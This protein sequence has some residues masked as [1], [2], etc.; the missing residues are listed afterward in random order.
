M[1]K[2][3]FL[4]LM[5]TALL[6]GGL[7][8]RANGKEEAKKKVEKAG[9][10]YVGSSKCKTCHA[11]TYKSWEKTKMADTFELLKPKERAEAKKKAKLKPEH[12]YS[13]DTNC[14]KCHT[15]GYKEPGGFGHPEK[16]EKSP[17][18]SVS[19][20]ACHGPGSEYTKIMKTVK[21]N[22]KAAPGT[23]KELVAAGLI[24]PGRTDVTT[25]KVKEKEVMDTSKLVC[26]N[27]HNKDSPMYQKFDPAERLG[28]ETA[29]HSHSKLQYIEH[30]Y[31]PKIE[32]AAKKKEK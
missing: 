2:R 29:I 15:T 3:M 13:S 8:L 32:P 23:E 16:S 30:D 19:C 21:N 12:D 17:L 14:L 6:V 5:V 31:S 26:L 27:C 18:T 11:A 20:E 28:Q 24:L 1:I 10:S 25:K 9:P 4:C 7:S 22:K